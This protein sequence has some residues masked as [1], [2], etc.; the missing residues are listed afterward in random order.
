MYHEF[1]GF[2]EKP[3]EL[4]P[5]PKFLFLTPSHQEIITSTM[6]GIKNRRGFISI[7]G[8]VG[9]GKT[10]LLRF[11]LGKLE[12]EKKVKTVLLFHPTITFKE[13][14]SNILLDLCL[15]IVNGGKRAL[16]HQLNDYLVQMNTKDETLVIL[17]DEAQGLPK[18]VMGEL[19]MLPREENL[20]IVFVGQPEF[21]D[22]LRS[23]GL[24]QLKQRIGIERQIKVLSEEESKDYID[25]RLR[26]VKSSS[27]QRFTPKAISMIC[28]HAQGVPR[29]INLLCDNALLRGY[30]LSQKRIDVDII[31][32]VIKDMEGP[33]P[34]KTFL[35]PLITV[36]KELRSF[37]PRLNS[38]LSRASLIVLSL[39]CL[40]GIV[41]LVDRL[42]Q[43]GPAKTWD[44]KPLKSIQPSLTPS[45]PQK[46]EEEFSKSDTQHPMSHSELGLS[47]LPKPVS[48]PPAPLTSLEEDK[49]MEIVTIKKGQTIYSLTKKYYHRVN[50]T[51]MDFILDSNPDIKDVHLVLIDQKIKVPKITEESLIV[52]TPDNTYKMNVGTFQ[53][54]NPAKYYS[55]ERGLEGKEIEILPR[56][57][58]TQDMWYRVVIGNFD[59]QDEALRMTSMLREKGL[60]PAFGGL[61]YMK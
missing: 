41:Y 7:I 49:F 31:R 2:S 37:H 23:Q 15:E 27:S 1:Y 51:L 32:E 18:E 6:D 25:H 11:L 22:R 38:F 5:D 34:Q 46:L 30:S 47:E 58:S 12:A 56:K 48:Q 52:K 57:V 8:E 4:L 16:L 53:A 19:G 20:Q 10:T 26:L 9:T 17:I 3:F 13:L 29:L 21:E 33:F 36:V 45:S 39:L 55:D 35:S 14:L 54:P 28:S 42:F 44:I 59:S 61:P 40:G 43:P 50:P 24:R 60:L